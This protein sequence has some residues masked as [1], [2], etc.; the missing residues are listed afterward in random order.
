MTPMEALLNKLSKYNGSLLASQWK[1]PTNKK[2]FTNCVKR[3]IKLYYSMQNRNIGH[4]SIVL[5]IKE[6][7]AFFRMYIMTH[8]PEAGSY[9]DVLQEIEEYAPEHTY[10]RIEQ[11]RL[12]E[13]KRCSICRVS[14]TDPAYLIFITEEGTEMRSDPIGIFCLKSLYGKLNKFTDSLKVEWEID[15]TVKGVEENARD[16]LLREI[17]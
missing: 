9:L 8:V 12:R 16:M 4:P 14:L 15:V 1:V 11:V 6:I 5:K 2:Q 10:Q 7:A 3:L 13:P 17:S